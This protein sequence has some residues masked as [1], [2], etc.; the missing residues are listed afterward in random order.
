MIVS[1]RSKETEQIW[2]GN[3]VKKMPINIQK[4]G[5]RKLRM[6]NN[7]Q[8]IAD[9]RIPPSNRLEKLRGSLNEFYSIR[10]NKQWR[11]IFKWNNGN[12]SEVGTR[13]LD[14][15]VVDYHSKK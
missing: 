7:S 15:Q 11:I 9:L 14:G 2:D 6:L 3:R 4:N 5:Y 1:F 8:N 13:L 10:I 12:A